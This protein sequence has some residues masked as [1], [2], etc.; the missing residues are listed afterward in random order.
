MNKRDLIVDAAIKAA[1]EITQ[2]DINQRLNLIIESMK[3]ALIN[4]DKITIANFGTFYVKERK[5]KKG[6]NPSTGEIINIPS[7]RVIK[8]KPSNRFLMSE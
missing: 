3:E 2:R 6:R 8:F 4:G 5:E 1:G 7:K